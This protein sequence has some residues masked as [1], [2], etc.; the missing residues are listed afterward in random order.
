LLGDPRFPEFVSNKGDRARITLFR[1]LFEKYSKLALSTPTDRSVA[2]SGL[3]SRF[4]SACE[5]E[6]CYGIFQRFLHWSILWQRSGD[7]M[8]RI[9]P[10]PKLPSWSWMAYKGGISYMNIPFDDVEWSNAV[11]CF[12]G[13]P[14]LQAPVR[15]FL[16]YTIE[17]QNERCTILA[18]G[19]ERG[20]LKFD[21]EDITDIQILKCIVVGRAR[22]QETDD[23]EHYI[24]VVTQRLEGGHCSYERVGV[25]SIQRRHISFQGGEF[26]ARII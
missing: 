11:K 4:A 21:G 19:V 22:R 1:S 7:K 9:K 17:P 12:P 13:K 26:K 16:H 6:V 15:E 14:E 3:E 5:T 2:I 10:P 8:V 20:W 23:Q 25:G 18:E 24:L